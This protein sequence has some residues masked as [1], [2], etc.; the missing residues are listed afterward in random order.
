MPKVRALIAE[1][2]MNLHQIV[3]DILE[4]TFKDVAINRAMNT[5]MLFKKLDGN[6]EHIDMLIYDLHFD[7]TGD[8]PAL[9]LI[10]RRM[11]EL[12]G[13]IV[14]L[15]S[16]GDDVRHNAHAR[17]LPYVIHPLSLDDFIETV[18][19]SYRRRKDE[20]AREKSDSEDE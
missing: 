19:E 2:D 16:K 5:E 1:E 3:C 9:P 20:L 17:D 7:E 14:I 4:M 10:R 8:E 18:T 15:A 13:R 11:P 6:V 12:D